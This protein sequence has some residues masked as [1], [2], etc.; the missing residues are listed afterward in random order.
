MLFAAKSVNALILDEP[1]NHLDLEALTALEEVLLTYQGTVVIV[2]HD[3][4][5]LS[6][7][8]LTHLYLLTDG[9]LQLLP[10]FDLYLLN[11]QKQS[12]NLLNKIN[13]N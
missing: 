5:L 11:L 1:S 8:K 2:S 12:Q 9:R 13:I 6:K 7:I 10:D 3:R 4:Y